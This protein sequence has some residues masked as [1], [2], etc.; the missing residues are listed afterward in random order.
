MKTAPSVNRTTGSPRPVV[1]VPFSIPSGL[2]SHAQ[3]L[4]LAVPLPIGCVS[5]WIRW[6]ATGLDGALHEVQHRVLAKWPDGSA[7]WTL[8]DLQYSRTTAS[9]RQEQLAMLEAEES[10]HAEGTKPSALRG[11]LQ[12]WEPERDVRYN[13]PSSSATVPLIRQLGEAFVVE[14]GKRLFRITRGSHVLESVTGDGQPWLDESGCRLVC[15]DEKG[16]LHLFQVD[17]I[18]V[19]DNG[20]VRATLALKGKLGK[21]GLRISARLSFFADSAL[22]RVEF[23]VEN[24]RRAR[25]QGGYW[26]LGDPG[27]VLVQELALEMAASW[28]INEQITWCEQPNSELQTTNA[29]SFSLYQDSSG[30]ENWHCR[31]HVNREGHVKQRFR[32]YIVKNGSLETTG[33]RANPTVAML[34]HNRYIACAIEEFWQK[35]PSA[36][37]LRGTQLRAATWPIHF[38]DLHELQG[39][40]HNSRVVWLEFG[41]GQPNTLNQLSWVYNPA[42]PTVDANWIADSGAIPFM[43]NS[44]MKDGPQLESI[45]DSAIVGPESL[46]AKREAID[47]YG[48]RN[49]GD[50][51]ADHEAAF[52]VDSGTVIS[53][54]NNQ[55]DLLY[56]MLIQF[57]K[58]EDARWW[59][60]A[61]PLARHLMN[62]DIYHTTEDKSAYNGGMFWHTAHYHDAATCSHRSY[63]KNMQGKAVSAP[64]G[65]PGNE[66]NYSTGLL[67]YHYL[68]GSIPARDSV[69][70]MAEWVLAMDDGDQH[71]LGWVS[72]DPTGLATCT[73]ELSFQGPGRGASNSIMTLLNAWIASSNSLYLDKACEF[74]RRTIHPQDDVQQYDLLDA[75]NRWSY[76]VYLQALVFF[77]ELTRHATQYNAIRAY[78]LES[79]LHYARWMTENERMYLDHAETLEYPTETWAAQD[80]RKGVVL[81]MAASLCPSDERQAIAEKGAWILDRAW[82]SLATFPTRSCTR[83]VAI[84]LQQC[85]LQQFFENS[86]NVYSFQASR[87]APQFAWTAPTSF[88]PQ[89]LLVRR[90]LGSR[91][92]IST[93]VARLF[94]PIFCRS[95]IRKSWLASRFRNRCFHS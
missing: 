18:K 30:G 16:R 70:E 43:P 61:D 88:V 65:G 54:Y 10:G 55:Y 75:E 57:L 52:S 60:L 5:D 81:L 31:N 47:E 56:G 20:P 78:A 39:G 6:E 8:I 48:W 68:T 45:L 82:C 32:G 85:Y 12:A 49:Y 23:T 1:E 51:W 46:F 41:D 3:P 83:P 19:E 25:H 94:Q 26:D 44:L 38:D 34:G 69:V 63:S 28:S 7:K 79:L 91:S 58:T 74:I 36:I 37:D 92:Q 64:G 86:A 9:N 53:H 29:D 90:Q 14:T 59:Q 62:I 22:C 13:E 4:R 66:H 80:L 40:E 11:L 67:L 24:P 17:T 42:I 21:T 71:I 93:F 27:S 73:R 89:R 95:K 76:T 15:L 2:H 50:V 77:I 87:P 84:V 72:H 33:L 35:G